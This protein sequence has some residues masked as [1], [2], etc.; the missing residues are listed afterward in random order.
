MKNPTDFIKKAERLAPVSNE[1][2]GA[3]FVEF[4]DHH[5]EKL[6]EILGRIL[7]GDENMK[8]FI[9]RAGMMPPE[10]S[11]VDEEIKQFCRIPYQ[12]GDGTIAACPGDLRGLKGCPPH[13][14]P[15][16]TT[17]GLLSKAKSFLIVQLEGSLSQT[18]Q[19]HIHPFVER[20]SNSLSE[21]GYD[22]LERYASGPCRVCPQGCGD[23]P[24]CRQPERRLFAPEACGYWVNTLCEKSSDFP[25]CGG[26][27]QE[28]RWIKD[29]R[30]PTQDT[31]SVR[32][33]TGVLLG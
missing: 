22:V 20:V 19:S 17:I 5:R 29:W 2:P 14:P 23:D 33:V 25:I 10:Q 8:G 7:D 21:H 26:G 31:D 28:I 15:A 3:A 6:G 30:L 4:Y 27:P 24:E 18:R 9:L 32:Y 1:M 16:A 13:A 11:V 12:T